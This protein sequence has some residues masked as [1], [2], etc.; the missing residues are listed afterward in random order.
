MQSI[1]MR[2]NAVLVFSLVVL[3]FFAWCCAMTTYWLDDIPSGPAIDPLKLFHLKRTRRGEGA[4][5]TFS[6]SADFDPVFN[7][8]VRQLF[9]YV[10]AEYET[11]DHSSNGQTLLSNQVVVWDRVL[12]L[13]GREYP[14]WQHCPHG[15]DY[16]HEDGGPCK[17]DEME[18]CVH[19]V[20]L[21]GAGD[22]RSCDS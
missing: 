21:H 20:S 6:L 10:T 22:A 17:E 11:I 1:W 19:M 14:F 9:I 18:S 2:I 7:W 12:R 3:G 13:D 5:F 8:N 16:C 15:Q 4:N